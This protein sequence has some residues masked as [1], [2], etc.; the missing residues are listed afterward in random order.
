MNEQHIYLLWYIAVFVTMARFQNTIMPAI[1]PA[2]AGNVATHAWT[3]LYK[4]SQEFNSRYLSS[5]HTMHDWLLHAWS[6]H[7]HCPYLYRLWVACHWSVEEQ[8]RS[9][10]RNMLSA[11]N[12]SLWKNWMH[13]L[14]NVWLQAN[15]YIYTH[16]CNAVPLVWGSLRLTQIMLVV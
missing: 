11:W 3:K 10:P 2:R 6:D 9:I 12:W 7:N 15:I 13:C 4:W 5:I 8:T 1:S 14:L 16:L